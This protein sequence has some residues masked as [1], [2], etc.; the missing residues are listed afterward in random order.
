MGQGLIVALS[1]L[2]VKP[3]WLNYP[4][5]KRTFLKTSFAS[6][7]TSA[8]TVAQPKPAQASPKI[9]WGYRGDNDPNHWANL[10]DDY[11]TCALGH[12]QSPIDLPTP[13]AQS[14][15]A[16]T[17]IAFDYHDTTLQLLNNGRTIQVNAGLS[18]RLT[19]DG[20]CFDLLQFHFHSPSEHTQNGQ[21]YPMEIHLVHRSQATEALSVVSVLAQIGPSNVLLNQ[22][23]KHLPD[24]S[25]EAKTWPKTLIN[26]KYL[27][28]TDTQ[29]F[30]RYSGSLTTPPCTE[31]V[32]WLVMATPITVSQSQVNQFIRGIGPNARPI[33]PYHSDQSARRLP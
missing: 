18:D 29:K 30:F 1:T 33:Q 23:W 15:S 4:V 11:Q 9:R 10:S 13:L 17:T 6:L 28:P 8:L 24:A 31:G 21:H 7:L 5:N 32:T 3:L 22:I 25:P 12:H 26:A 14:V 19:L 16:L 2:A 27:L 20:Q